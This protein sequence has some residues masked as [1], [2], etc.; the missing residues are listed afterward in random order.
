MKE[1]LTS[2]QVAKI[3]QISRRSVWNMIHDGRLKAVIISGDKRKSY[4]I[5][6]GELD[7]FVAK[8]YGEK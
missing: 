2:Q 1:Y 5:L 7:R 8:Q 4:R 3:L 6:R